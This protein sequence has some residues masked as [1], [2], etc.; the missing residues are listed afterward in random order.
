MTRRWPVEDWQQ[1]GHWQWRE[2]GNG[3]DRHVARWL[4]HDGET[5]VDVPAKLTGAGS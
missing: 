2:G 4:V 1:G 3:I 5:L